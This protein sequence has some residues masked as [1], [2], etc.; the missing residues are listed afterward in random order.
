MSATA[1]NLPL[2]KALKDLNVADEMAEAAA[3]A[4]MPDLSRLALREDVS[5][6]ATRDEL[7]AEIAGMRHEVGARI[8]RASQQ[9]I[10]WTIGALIALFGL[11]FAAQRYLP[12]AATEAPRPS[13]ERAAPSAPPA[14][15]AP[16]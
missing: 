7:H 1:F 3:Q 6:L 5:R 14:T 9:Q 12:P 2:Y 10:V 11:F 16:R 15:S 8:A 4:A 13:L